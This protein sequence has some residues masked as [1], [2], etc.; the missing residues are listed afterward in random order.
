MEAT[1]PVLM[2]SIAPSKLRVPPHYSQAQQPGILASGGI[3]GDAHGSVL[4]Q[5]GPETLELL[6]PVS[7]PGAA[8]LRPGIK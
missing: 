2:K 1:F 6:G 7:S 4:Q 5:D 8:G 3:D